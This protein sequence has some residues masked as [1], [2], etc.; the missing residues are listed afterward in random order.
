MV[1]RSA[2]T[3]VEDDALLTPWYSTFFDSIY[4]EHLKALPTDLTCREVEFMLDKLCLPGGASVLDL[5]CGPGR[6]AIEFAR[7]GYRVTGQDLS[8]QYLAVGRASALREGKSLDWVCA[9]MRHIPF[10]DEFDT[11]CVWYSSYGYLETDAE[12]L[13]V[14]VSISGALKPGG[15]L[16]LDVMSQAFLVRNYIPYTWKACND[17][18]VLLESL[19]YDMLTGRNSLDV[20]AI[21]PTGERTSANI[22]IRM[23]TLTELARMLAEA[24]LRIAGTWGGVDGSDYSLHSPRMIVLAVK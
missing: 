8:E 12:D 19:H 15:K 3:Q 20:T 4:L 7:R 13:R 10:K 18:T 6:H 24:G 16:I 22:Q 14:L 21:R 11:C 5:C 9:D 17:G 2:V 1:W 23:Y